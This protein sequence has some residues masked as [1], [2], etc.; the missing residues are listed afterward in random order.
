MSDANKALVRGFYD[1]INRGDLDAFLAKLADDFVEHEAFPGIPPTKQGVGILFEQMRKAFSGF[2]MNVE[3][4]A[5]DGDMVVARVTMSGTHVGEF[6]GI[7]PSGKEVLVPLCDWT[8]VR[9]GKA[10][11][12][13][14]VSDTSALTNS[15]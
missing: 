11:E 3:A 5:A 7:P 9:G 4:I 8:R 14:G 12:H 13:W 15:A 10:V 6:M 2:R 1:D